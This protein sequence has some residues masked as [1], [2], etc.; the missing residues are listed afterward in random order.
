MK[1]R[2]YDEARG[3]IDYHLFDCI[4]P[5]MQSSRELVIVQTGIHHDNQLYERMRRVR[6]NERRQIN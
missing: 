6:C 2:F 4:I 1:P 3:E 5:R